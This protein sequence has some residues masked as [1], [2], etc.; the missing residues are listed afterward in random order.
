MVTRLVEP[1]VDEAAYLDSVVDE[2]QNGKHAQFFE[3]IRDQWKTRASRYRQNS[4]NPEVV[5]PWADVSHRKDAFINL[6]SSPAEKSIHGAV[7]AT[8]RS[9][10]LQLC[11]ACGEEGSPNTLDHYLPKERYPEFSILPHNLLPMCDT[12]QASKGAQTVDALNR[13]MFIHGYYDEFVDRQIVDLRIGTP[14][15]A[16]AS[17][18]LEPTEALAQADADLVRRHLE[19]LK[20]VSRYHRFFRSEYLHLLR[21]VNMM[22]DNGQE[23][24]TFLRTF[25]DGERLRSVNSWRHVFYSGVLSSP[26]LVDFLEEAE[27]PAV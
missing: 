19:G 25:R 23:T 3:G 13:R 7:I 21:I 14:F 9:R 22:R 27:L 2:R 20:I 15:N 1:D 17:I 5:V 4:G 10:T 16:P 18:S 12:C 8:L 6:Y 11:P 24:V 26:D